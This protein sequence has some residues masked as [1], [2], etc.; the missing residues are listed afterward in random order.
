[1]YNRI[2][3]TVFTDPMMG[4]GYESDP[5]MDRLREE[6][7]GQVEFRYVMGLLVRDVSDFMLPEELA[8]APGPGIRRYCR[9]LAGIYKSGERFG[10]LP[11]KMDSFCLF[12]EN[13]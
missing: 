4:L 9:R 11:M 8:M 3:I 7:A 10:G 6:Y 13:H 1:M 5:I 12:D 2:I